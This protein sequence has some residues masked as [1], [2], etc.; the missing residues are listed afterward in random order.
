MGSKYE[1]YRRDRYVNI[2][3]ESRGRNVKEWE[4]FNENC[5]KKNG[6]NI[7]NHML[8]TIEFR[9]KLLFIRLSFC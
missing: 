5:G 8:S 3:E 2:I 9:S 6:F 7:P 1:K 4:K